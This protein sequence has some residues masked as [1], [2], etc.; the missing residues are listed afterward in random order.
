MLVHRRHFQSFAVKNGNQKLFVQFLQEF[1]QIFNWDFTYE[2]CF[3]FWSIFSLQTSTWLANTNE[4]CSNTAFRNAI[5]TN[6]MLNCWVRLSSKMHIGIFVFCSWHYRE[7]AHTFTFTLVVWH[8]ISSLK[9]QLGSTSRGQLNWIHYTW[10]MAIH[11]G[12]MHWFYYSMRNGS[13][14]NFW[15]TRFEYNLNNHKKTSTFFLVRNGLD[16]LTSNRI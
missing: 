15:L 11:S 7:S 12:C 14:R 16:P 8:H 1:I 6:G 9:L 3:I 2:F 5:K 10:A 13:Y 4:H